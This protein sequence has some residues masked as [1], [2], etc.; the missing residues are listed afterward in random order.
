M[1]EGDKLLCLVAQKYHTI[2]KNKV[3]VCDNVTFDTISVKEVPGTWSAHRFKKI[4]INKL[5]KI[6][7]NTSNED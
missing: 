2:Q 5:N 1:K 7:Y 6:L 3:Y 4:N